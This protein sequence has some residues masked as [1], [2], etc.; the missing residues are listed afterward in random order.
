MWPFKN[1]VEV[2]VDVPVY[3]YNKAADLVQDGDALLCW[4]TSFISR[5]ITLW[6]GG[7][8]HVAILRRDPGIYHVSVVETIESKGDR[9]TTLK[10][11]AADYNGTGR[12]YPGRLLVARSPAISFLSSYI[13]K[14][15]FHTLAMDCGRYDYK[16]FVSI[17][18]FYLTKY[19]IYG[20]DDAYICSERFD[21]FTRLCKVNIPREHARQIT[22]LDVLRWSTPQYEIQTDSEV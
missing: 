8:S 1:P 6:T 3:P 22:P 15:A 13:L 7:P 4:G 5:Q 12:P 17:A 2:P 20:V 16:E 9:T 21:R 14:T 18:W 19:K 10:N 11:Y